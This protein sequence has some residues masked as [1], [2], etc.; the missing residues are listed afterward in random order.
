MAD[1]ANAI[2]AMATTVGSKIIVVYATL[3]GL[4]PYLVEAL[5]K[6]GVH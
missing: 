1:Q 3:A 4:K 5:A 2:I 6:T